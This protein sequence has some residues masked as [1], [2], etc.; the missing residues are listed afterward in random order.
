MRPIAGSL[1]IE[2]WLH[3][4]S[5]LPPK[6]WRIP[7]GRRW[8]FLAGS[9]RR[10]GASCK[11]SAATQHNGQ[12][13]RQAEQHAGRRVHEG[14][15]RRDRRCGGGSVSGEA[16]AGAGKVGSQC[17]SSHPIAAMTALVAGANTASALA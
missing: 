10:R 12:I 15:A 11:H 1:H 4:R 17:D 7:R 8:T 14:Q 3:Q 2:S 6:L 16:G 13:D 5:L 9:W